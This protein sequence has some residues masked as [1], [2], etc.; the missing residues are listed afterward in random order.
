MGYILNRHFED[1]HLEQKSQ[2]EALQYDKTESEV[3]YLS[4][5]K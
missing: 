4:P 5:K 2:S 3:Q 1:S